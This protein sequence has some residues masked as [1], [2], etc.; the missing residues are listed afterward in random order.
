MGRLLASIYADSCLKSVSR[1]MTGAFGDA[2]LL[3]RR[4]RVA[5]RPE[6][7]ALKTLE[8]ERLLLRPYT[9]DDVIPLHSTI[10][11]DPEVCHFFCGSTR[12]LE[13][14]RERVVYRIFQIADGELGFLAVV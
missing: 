7:V 10:Y 8:T 14:I 1:R 4:W 13:Q 3:S 11:S 12:T 9:L 2:T 6:R 5:A